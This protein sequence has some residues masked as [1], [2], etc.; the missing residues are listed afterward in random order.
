MKKLAMSLPIFLGASSESEEESDE[1]P[2]EELDEVE[3]SDRSPT[4]SFNP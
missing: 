3:L 4:F 1:S 2:D